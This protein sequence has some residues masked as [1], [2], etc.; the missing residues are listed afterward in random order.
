MT[1]PTLPRDMGLHNRKV[2]IRHLCLPRPLENCDPSPD[3]LN[4]IATKKKNPKTV[5]ET[6]EAESFRSEARGDISM[7]AA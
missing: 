4:V 3:G 1:A 6:S 7:A 5:M 2:S